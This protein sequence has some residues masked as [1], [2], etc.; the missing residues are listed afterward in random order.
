MVWISEPIGSCWHLV[1]PDKEIYPCVAGSST[2]WPR[3]FDEGGKG[4]KKSIKIGGLGRNHPP[5]V[6]G[7]KSRFKAYFTKYLHNGSLKSIRS[8]ANI[9]EHRSEREYWAGATLLPRSYIYRDR[10]SC[11][12]S[13]SKGGSAGLKEARP[14]SLGQCLENVECL[15]PLP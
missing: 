5:R 11:R 7:N 15:Y 6:R 14:G 13:H 10:M 3:Q 1:V 8:G 9:S 12:P 4:N 2:F